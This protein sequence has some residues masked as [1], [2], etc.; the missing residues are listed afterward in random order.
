[1]STTKPWILGV[2]ASHN[3]AACLLHGD[4]LVVAIQEERLNRRKR[5]R[6]FGA[7]R[8]LCID[9]CLQAA[10]I[11]PGDLSLVVAASQHVSRFDAR[12][13]LTLNPGLQLGRNG[14]PELWISHHRA[15]ALSAFALSGFDE[16]AVLV[17]DGQGSIYDDLEDDERAVVQGGLRAGWEAT[18][19][20]HGDDA[21]LAPLE[22][23]MTGKDGYIVRRQG[24]AGMASFSSL[25]GIFTAVAS[26]IF[27]GEVDAGKVMGLAPYGEPIY[28]AS[29]FFTVEDGVFHFNDR[30]ARRF[31]DDQRWPK[32]ERL[33]K[34]LAASAQNAIE[35][36]VLYLARRLRSSSP[37]SRLCY[38]GGV[39][40]NSVANERIWRESGFQD[41]FVVPAAEDSGCALGAAYHGLFQLTGQ[42]PKTR[43]RRDSLGRTYVAA[44][45]ARAV[46]ETPAVQVTHLAPSE[47]VPTTARLLAE[48]KIV[49]WFQGG[50]ELGPRAL[51]QR[52][53]LCDPRRSDA[54]DTLNLRVKHREAFRPFAPVILREAAHEWM[55]VG[56][57][58]DSPFMLRVCPFRE[59][60][61]DKVP[62]V[63]HV[64]GTGRLQTVTQED[65]GIF[66]DLVRAF[67]EATGVPI[68]V[69]TSF[70]VM[71][72]PI[73]ETPEDALWCL[74]Y[75]GVDVCVLGDVIVEKAPDFKGILQLVPRVTARV[76]ELGIAVHAE[77]I[78][79][80]IAD[81]TACT[82]TVDTPWGPSKQPIRPALLGLLSRIDGRLTGW[83]LLDLLRADDDDAVDEKTLTQALAELRRAR[84]IAFGEVR[85]S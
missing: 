64:D 70:N 72:E 1:M 85:R 11:R 26:Q 2:N 27:G 74:L 56:P 36:A 9:Y 29:D 21:T 53:I 41:A 28:P 66:Y 3:G 10:G 49:G 30:V 14:V 62:G 6:I 7:E 20:Y 16:A 52:T 50:S 81:D 76:V 61:L 67:G 39:A 40:L 22:K 25:G 24:Q 42:S 82:A 68:L 65:N 63:V 13:D 60:V 17:I 79:L 59:G 43:L 37:S 78:Q 19:L 33:Y 44:D 4:E 35:E 18:S 83:E 45:I 12:E 71:G 5:Q 84:V 23:H 58:A 32:H 69:G 57:S 54:K 75:T 31:C 38:A 73:V 15:H 47:V 77:G 51:G 34:D 48:G 55:D 8:A 46:S 80:G